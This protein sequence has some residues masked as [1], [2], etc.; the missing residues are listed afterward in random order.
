MYKITWRYMKYIGKPKDFFSCVTH[1]LIAKIPKAIIENVY[2]RWKEKS[3]PNNVK[4]LNNKTNKTNRNISFV[5]RH[6]LSD[7]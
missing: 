6:W 1:E 4:T 7:W 2:T 5:C 3:F